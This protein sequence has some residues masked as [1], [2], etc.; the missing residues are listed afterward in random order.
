MSK[1]KNKKR[2]RD[3]APRVQFS[4]KKKDGKRICKANIGNNWFEW[5][6]LW[7]NNAYLLIYIGDEEYEYKLPSWITFDNV[8]MYEQG[9]TIIFEEI[10]SDDDAIK[11][12]LSVS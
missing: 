3:H 12:D 9:S 7:L 6:M 2:Q 11:T 5:D 1:K 10:V 8:K 4:N